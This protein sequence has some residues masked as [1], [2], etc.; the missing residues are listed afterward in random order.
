MD[1]NRKK[2]INKEGKKKE[3]EENLVRNFWEE[4]T[5]DVTTF[6]ARQF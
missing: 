4:D 3:G 5:G 6:S 1:Q 2:T